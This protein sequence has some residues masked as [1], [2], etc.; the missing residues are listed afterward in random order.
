MNV[1]YLKRMKAQMRLQK[2]WRSIGRQLF[3]G[4]EKFCRHTIGREKTQIATVRFARFVF[5]NCSSEFAKILAAA[6]TYGDIQDTPLLRLHEL[7]D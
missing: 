3:C 2:S 5:G 7:G 4:L 6:Q 1:R